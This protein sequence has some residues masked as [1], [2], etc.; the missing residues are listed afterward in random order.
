[1]YFEY[2]GFTVITKANWLDAG[3]TN[4]QYLKDSEKGVLRIAS[5]QWH[6]QSLID[7]HSLRPNRKSIIQA[8]FGDPNQLI[9]IAKKVSKSTEHLLLAL[10]R[11]KDKPF[12]EQ[13]HADYLDFVNG[14]KE[15]Y[16][17]KSGECFLPEDFRYK[18]R[19][20][21]L[22]VATVWNY[23]KDVL[24]NTAVYADRIFYSKIRRT[25]SSV[26]IFTAF[27]P[28]GEICGTLH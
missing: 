16:D 13:V 4:N 8:K 24:N 12:V 20:L 10:W 19:P 26:K 2:N 28:D 22:S 5:R 9:G 15:F 7:F 27:F 18:G 17:K 3:L 6:N 1:M 21:E 25:S 23:L 14:N 11:K